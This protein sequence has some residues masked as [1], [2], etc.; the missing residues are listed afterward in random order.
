MC[1]LNYLAKAKADGVSQ[2]DHDGDGSHTR[3]NFPNGLV[4]VRFYMI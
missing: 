1:P 3:L 2:D 4:L